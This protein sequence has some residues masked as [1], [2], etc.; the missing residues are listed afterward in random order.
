MGSS[1]EWLSPTPTSKTTSAM[2]TPGNRDG[3]NPNTKTTTENLIFTPVN[4]SPTKTT[5]V[6]ELVRMLNSTPGQQSL[7]V[8]A[9]PAKTSQSS[10]LLNTTKRLIAAEGT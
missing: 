9:T 10:S 3:S 2:E 7:I 6:S 4:S 1:R 8:L 5:K